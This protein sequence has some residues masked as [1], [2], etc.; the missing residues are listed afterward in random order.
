MIYISIPGINQYNRVALNVATRN[1][2]VL[3]VRMSNDLHVALTRDP[4]SYIAN[5]M[6][7]IA[8]GRQYNTLSAIR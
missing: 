3:N 6:Y 5:T 4:D 8:I 7:E 1:S 2:I